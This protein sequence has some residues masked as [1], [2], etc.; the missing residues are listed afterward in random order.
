MESLVLVVFGYCLFD[1]P[2][3][4]FNSGI[5]IVVNFISIHLYNH[6]HSYWKTEQ[7]I[8]RWLYMADD[9]NDFNAK[10]A[11]TKF[12]NS[13]VSTSPTPDISRYIPTPAAKCT[14]LSNVSLCLSTVN[15]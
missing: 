13:S 5:T 10:M 8:L 9:I 7:S 4:Y 12:V 11:G 15:A 2:Y 6:T 14:C 3:E 1:G